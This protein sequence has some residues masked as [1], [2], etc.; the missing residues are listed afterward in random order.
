MQ[1]CQK[2]KK[3]KEDFSFLVL[4][5]NKTAAI[6]VTQSDVSNFPQQLVCQLEANAASYNSN[7]GI[8]YI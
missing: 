8:K 3:K 2:Q 5:V 1:E 4:E 7:K 6:C